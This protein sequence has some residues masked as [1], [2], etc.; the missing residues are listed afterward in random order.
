[1]EHAPER[2]PGPA[3]IRERPD[4]GGE[5]VH[6]VVEPARFPD[7]ASVCDVLQIGLLE[8]VSSKGRSR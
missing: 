1:M 4:A 8:E 7:S 6:E 5:H 3:R 2:V